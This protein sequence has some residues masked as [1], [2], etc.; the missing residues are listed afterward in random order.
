MIST[1]GPHYL[2]TKVFQ[3]PNGISFKI[4]LGER[5]VFARSRKPAS[6]HGIPLGPLVSVDVEILTTCRSVCCVTWYV[7]RLPRKHRKLNY[8]VI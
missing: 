3:R 4:A 5:L 8:A 2:N 7:C 6:E 1:F